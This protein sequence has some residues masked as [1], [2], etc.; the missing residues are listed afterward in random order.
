LVDIIPGQQISI[1]C[2]PL[3]V[4]ACLESSAKWPVADLQAMESM[5]AAFIL[6]LADI[7]RN[8]C[9][10]STAPSVT[11]FIR[12]DHSI[13]LTVHKTEILFPWY[14]TEINHYFS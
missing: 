14:E 6:S 1:M 2:E 4:I 13:Q 12:I 3:V 9:Q 7:I 11:A 8:R 10:V 5:I